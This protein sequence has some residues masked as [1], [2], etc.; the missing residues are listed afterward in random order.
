M[1]V[2]IRP[3]SNDKK[4]ESKLAKSLSS[5]TSLNDDLECQFCEALIQN[6]RNI[7]V[8]NTSEAEFMTVLTS[9]CKQT[10]G[11]AKEVNYSALFIIFSLK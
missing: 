4:F 5:M 2:S 1:R 7:L 3:L 9:L 6:V 8:A 10:G 11:F